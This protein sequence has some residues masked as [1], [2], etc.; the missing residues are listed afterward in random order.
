MKCAVSGIIEGVEI[1][2][3]N[4]KML[5]NVYGAKC[6]GIDAVLVTVEVEITVGIGI[7]L[8]GLAGAAVKESLL[9]T[10][11]ALQFLGYRI[12]GRKIVINLAP[13]DVRKNGSGY[14]LPIAIGILAA[15]GQCPADEIGKYIMMGELGLDGSVRAVRGSLPIAELA[16]NS[17]YS[18]C[19]L[20]A[21]SAGDAVPYYRDKVLAVNDLRDVVGILS[22]KKPDCSPIPF[23]TL[24]HSSPLIHP[25]SSSHSATPNQSESQSHSLLPTHPESSSHS[26]PLIRSESPSSGLI[27]YKLPSIQSL[28]PSA[29]R[30]DFADIVGQSAAKRAVEI[31]AAGGHNVILI[32]PPGSGKSSIAKAMIDILPP[33]SPEEALLT[34]KIYSVSGVPLPLRSLSDGSIRRPFRT[35]HHSIPQAALLGG[36]VDYIAPGEISLANG[37]VLFMDEFCEAP[38]KVTESLR[39]PIEDGRITISRL[40][41]KVTFPSSFI[42]V[43]ATNP[44]PCGYYGDGSKCVCSESQIHSYLS[45]LSGPIM[46]RIDMQVFMRPVSSKDLFNKK[47]EETSHEVAERV[48][49]A[50]D[51]QRSRFRDDGIFTNSEMTP[52]M[53]D[54]YCH[55]EPEAEKF[56]RKSIDS[57]GLSA[58]SYSRILRMSLTIAD[59]SGS[60][61]ISVE[62]IS[63]AI[64]YRFLDRSKPFK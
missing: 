52:A 17:G 54:R 31:A 20:P 3:K 58:R 50:R 33:M 25:E 42:F 49:S 6:V 40:K 44:C 35:P 32:G 57:L 19:I 5:I 38:R 34:C 63:E 10:M 7:H 2:S 55:L 46:D 4:K 43:A 13:A 60:E 45:K 30:M 29:D 26:A 8:V 64:S 51:I 37:G 9:R 27:Q 15:S 24:F 12:P 59:L 22:G 48:K 1:R 62:H 39:A 36:G 11:T 28:P 14:D 53:I 16:A 47:K 61:K 23:R 21:C 56:L 18:A 41:S